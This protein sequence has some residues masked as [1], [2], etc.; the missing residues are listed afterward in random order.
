MK[1]LKNV[2]KFFMVLTIIML[3]ITIYLVSKTYAVFYS[4]A[5]GNF[6]S[7]IAKWD[8]KVNNQEV[9]GRTEKDFSIDAF[10]IIND[11]N[12]KD[13]KIA[14]GSEGNFNIQI[15][16]TDTQVSIRYDITIDK[17]KLEEYRISVDSVTEKNNLTN[18]IKTSESTYTG[19]IPI[20]QINNKVVDNINILFKW[21]NDETKN[22]NDTLIGTI[23]N[24]KTNIPI[25]ITFSQYLGEEITEYTK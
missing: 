7:N 1:N 20:T 9:T 2:K 5:Q 16:S 4:E 19:I 10:N 13:G 6:T 21:K 24:S 14:P 12:V 17:E 11:A 25:N 3:V 8:I 22:D 23:A 18:I 15:D